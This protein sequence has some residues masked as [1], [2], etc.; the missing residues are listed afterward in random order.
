MCVSIHTTPRTDGVQQDLHAIIRHRAASPGR[1]IKVRHVIVLIRYLKRYESSLTS[2]GQQ[3]RR[4]FSSHTQST[5]AVGAHERSYHTPRC[6]YLAICLTTRET[7]ARL[8]A[9]TESN[10]DLMKKCDSLERFRRALRRSSAV[11]LIGRFFLRC[12]TTGTD[13]RY[14]IRKLKLSAVIALVR[15][16]DIHGD[17][18][19]FV[20]DARPIE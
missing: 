7:N 12:Q 1:C 3:F 13:R 6:T 14:N 20:T 16:T 15:S 19:I 5:T 9:H 2:R 17:S 4:S 10:V 18:R 8:S 11:Q